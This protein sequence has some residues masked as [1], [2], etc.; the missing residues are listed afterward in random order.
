MPKK[1]NIKGK[2]AVFLTV[3]I[4]LF[5][6]ILFSLS[7]LFIKQKQNESFF[8]Q[9]SLDR[10][11]NLDESIQ[12]S[13]TDL[14]REK[15]GLSVKIVNHSVIIKQNLPANLTNIDVSLADFESF[16]EDKVA[17]VN[18]DYAIS[19][20]TFNLTPQGIIYQNSAEN[21]AA[22][23]EL[24]TVEGI[25]IN[26]GFPQGGYGVCP[27]IWNMQSSGSLNLKVTAKD[28]LFNCETEQNLD[29]ISKSELVVN[30]SLGDITVTIENNELKIN[31]I[32]INPYMINLTINTENE[33]VAAIRIPEITTNISIPDFAVYGKARYFA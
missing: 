8:I 14:I 21:N 2:K 11:T 15:A 24:G 18:I 20:L 31:R 16:V 10:I 12:K 9:A 6:L 28:I 17:T 22:I 5:A 26:F 33:G 32:G 27:M 30:H 29:R 23:K 7:S 1:F 3:S 25:M 4:V 19:D 13:I